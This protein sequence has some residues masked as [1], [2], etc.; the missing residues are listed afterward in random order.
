M[1]YVFQNAVVCMQRK[2]L[3]T[4]QWNWWHLWGPSVGTLSTVPCDSRWLL[5]WSTWR[6]ITCLSGLFLLGLLSS[7]FLSYFL[8]WS[9]TQSCFLPL[10]SRRPTETKGYK[11]LWRVSVVH[12]YFLPGII[13]SFYFLIISNFR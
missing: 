3:P 13:N 12:Q 7:T 2:C 4:T 5:I 10:L 1:F 9:Y 11:D 8:G 6:V